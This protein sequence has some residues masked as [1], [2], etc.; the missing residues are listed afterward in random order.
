MRYR[1]AEAL[2]YILY[3]GVENFYWRRSYHKMLILEH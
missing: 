2:K 3:P 1:L